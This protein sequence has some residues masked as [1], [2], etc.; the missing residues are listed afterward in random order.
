MKTSSPSTRVT[1]PTCPVCQSDS[2]SPVLVAVDHTVSQESFDVWHCS[3]CQ[4][5][6]TQA[7]PDENAIGSYYQA[8]SYISHSNTRK[9][10]VNRLYQMVR[11]FTLVQK[12]KLIQQVSGLKTGSLLDI[13]C[14]TGEFLGT[15]QTAGWKCL[16]LEPDPG[17]RKQ[18][19]ENFQ[20]AVHPSDHLFELAAEQY[21]VISMWHVLEHVHRLH[22]Y[23][24]QIKSCLKPSGTLIIAVP[25]YQSLDAGKYEAEWAAYDVPRHLYHFSP[26]AMQHLLRDHGFELIKMKT[27]PFD[28]FYVSLLSEKY[29]HG[30]VRLISGFFT[31]LRSFLATIGHADRC[32][33]VMYIIRKAA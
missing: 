3:T 20:L 7:V 1:Y 29:I 27:M 26:T 9:G 13:G 25:N 31:G 21:D 8:E 18:A 17:A 33:S 11:D 16:G 28:A 24:D 2:I 23:L 15:M 19:K 32:S 22:L 4:L 6:F 5:R 14:G 10:L 30:K 12:R